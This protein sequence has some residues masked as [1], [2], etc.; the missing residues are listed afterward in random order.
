[1]SACALALAGGSPGCPPVFLYSVSHPLS[2]TEKPGFFKKPGFWANTF[3][4][5]KTAISLIPARQP[6]SMQYIPSFRGGAP[7]RRPG[8]SASF[9]LPSSIISLTAYIPGLSAAVLWE[10]SRN[11]LSFPSE[12]HWRNPSKIHWVRQGLAEASCQLGAGGDCIY[13]FFLAGMR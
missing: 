7:E 6:Q 4:Q 8:G 3:I 10:K 1:M 5:L 2:G 12:P 9:G 13:C 11:L